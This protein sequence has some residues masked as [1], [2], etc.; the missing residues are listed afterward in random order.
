M[1]PL[2]PLSALGA[3]PIYVLSSDQISVDV[4]TFGCFYTDLAYYLIK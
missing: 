4:S 3:P 1:S 2:A